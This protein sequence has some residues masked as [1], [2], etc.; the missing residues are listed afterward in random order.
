MSDAIDSADVMLYGVSLR[1]KESGNVSSRR[2]AGCFLRQSWLMRA[3]VSAWKSPVS[4]RGQL[5]SFIAVASNK[6]SLL[7]CAALFFSVLTGACAAGCSAHQQEVDMI[8]L[9]M[10]K[11]YKPKGWLGMILGT[12]MW[13]V[14]S[15]TQPS[16]FM[17]VGPSLCSDP[18]PLSHALA[19]SLYCNIRAGTRFMIARMTTRRPLKNA[20]TAS[21]ARS[22]IGV[23]V[24]RLL[25]RRAFLRHRHRLRHRPRLVRQQLR[26]QQLRLWLRLRL[27]LRLR[28]KFRRRR[29]LQSSISRRACSLHRRRWW[30]GKRPY[31]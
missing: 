31:Q 6:G 12:R 24:L 14:S 26:L 25:Y 22:V 20:S 16:R 29:S 30:C 10:M 4:L 1:Y 27:R 18:R 28:G 11:E 15:P 23:G 21:C 2:L 8:P 13:C 3:C 7:S 9:M 17:P 19:R 5:V